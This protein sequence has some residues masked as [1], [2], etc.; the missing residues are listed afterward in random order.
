MSNRR[1]TKDNAEQTVRTRGVGQWSNRGYAIMTAIAAVT[2]LAGV[3][4]FAIFGD[5]AMQRGAEAPTT[6]GPSTTGWGGRGN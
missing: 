5:P 6:Q 2:V 1:Q 4:A 3:S